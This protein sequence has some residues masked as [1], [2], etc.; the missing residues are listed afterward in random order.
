MIRIKEL[1]QH[2][3]YLKTTVPVLAGVIVVSGFLL[4]SDIARA[5]AIRN[6]SKSTINA[7]TTN[8][9]NTNNAA[10]Q[11][12]IQNIITKGNQ[13]IDRRLTTLD[14]LT[15][16]VAAAIHLSSSDQATL[17]NEVSSTTSGLTSLKSQLDSTTTIMAAHNNAEDIY[18]EYRVY[19][20]VAPKISLIKVADDQQV[21]QGKLTA[22][23]TKLQTRITTL[24]QSGKDTTQV[25]TM[26]RE[27]TNMNNEITAASKISSDIESSVIVLQPSDYNS[28]HAVLSGDNTQL[29]TAHADDQQAVTNAQNII[30]TLKAI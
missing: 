26:Q 12:R 1:T 13:E 2:L 7:S 9:S 22:L 15:I 24:Q 5:A 4:F 14:S 3:R 6:T 28:N 11:Q 16:K 23:S 29:K 10:V 20:L 27:L 17:S 25:Q 30:T 18:S 8:A 21:V 19:A